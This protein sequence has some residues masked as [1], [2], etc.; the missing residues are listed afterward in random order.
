MT[1]PL[2][3]LAAGFLLIVLRCAS[4]FVVVPLYGLP[5]I[6]MRI[7]MVAALSVSTVVFM[8]AGAPGF[9][10]W[11]HADRVV[12]AALSETFLGLTVGV[13]VRVVLDAAAAA[14]SAIGVSMSLSMGATYDPIHGSESPAVAQLLSLAALG[15]AVAAGLHR[16]VIAWLCRSVVDIAPGAPYAFEPLAARVVGQAAESM[17]LAVRLAFP[18][19]SAVTIGH[20]T[21]GLLNRTIPQMGISNIGFALAILAGLAA[22]YVTAPAAARIVAEAART[23]LAG[24]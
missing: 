7:R 12:L 15:F 3:P 1:S 14:G 4:L 10:A 21:L 22:L 6:P 9:A 20:L 13:G 11:D 2:L 18:V 16:E 23:A 19:L 17:A 5:A 8:G 24:G